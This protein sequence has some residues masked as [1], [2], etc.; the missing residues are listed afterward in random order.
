MREPFISAS[1]VD[2]MPEGDYKH[3]VMRKI[4]TESGFPVKL[5]DF[6]ISKIKV[7]SGEIMSSP[8]ARQ[9]IQ[10]LWR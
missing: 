6:M 7:D 3:A 5:V 4:L 2:T 1:A 10:G 9:V 8:G